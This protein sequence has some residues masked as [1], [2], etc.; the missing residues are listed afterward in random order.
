MVDE[1]DS[2][3]DDLFFD[4]LDEQQADWVRRFTQP[5]VQS[6]GGAGANEP[7]TAAVMAA[8]GRTS[9]N[10][11]ELDIQVENS[12]GGVVTARAIFDASIRSSA[13]SSALETALLRSTLQCQCIYRS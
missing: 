7:F 5:P 9:F 1:L 3:T 12:N 10:R 11:H 13:K 6:L 4:V 2:T 8:A